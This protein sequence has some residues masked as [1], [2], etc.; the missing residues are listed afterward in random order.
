MTPEWARYAWTN[1]QR[2]A[3]MTGLVFSE[4]YHQAVLQSP[5]RRFDSTML[6]RALT[7]AAELDTRL[8]PQLL[9]ALQQARYVA[10]L[11]TACAEIAGRITAQTASRFG[12]EVRESQ[13]IARIQNDE[14]LAQ[15]TL[16]RVQYTQ[17]LMTSLHIRRVPQLLVSV[18]G[19]MHAIPSALMYQGGVSVIAEIQSLLDAKPAALAQAD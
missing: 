5:E 3:A 14:V 17:T 8:E 13:C 18:N 10:G 11:D 12:F 15:L 19:A 2:I 6:N 16:A 7:C 1:D 4:R 9:H